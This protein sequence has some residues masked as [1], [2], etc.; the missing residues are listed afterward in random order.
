MTLT[1]DPGKPTYAAIEKTQ[2]EIFAFTSSIVSLRGGRQ[3]GKLGL[4]MTP[5]AYDIFDPATP[6]ILPV[7]TGNPPTFDGMTQCVIHANQGQYIA[8]VSDFKNTNQLEQQL[9]NLLLSA[10]NRK[11][12]AVIMDTITGQIKKQLPLILSLLYTNYEQITPTALNQKRDACTNLI[13]NPR[14][15]IDQI[16]VKIMS[17]SLMAQAAKSPATNEQ[18]INIGIIILQH[19]GFFT[20]DIRKCIKL[21]AQEH[22]RKTFQE[23]FSKS[24]LELELARP[25]A[26]SMG[27]HNQY[28]NSADKIVNKLYENISAD[29][30]APA[31]YY[32]K[33]E[34]AA[35]T[36][37]NQHMQQI[38]QATQQNTH[39]QNVLQKP[40]F[41]SS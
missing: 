21:P 29:T 8:R 32:E 7:H 14:E 40:Y 33:S 37:M 39:T 20:H 11:W 30:T 35:A 4:V 2:R 18:L 12:L 31:A 9:T 17:Y 22:N 15:P 34:V 6:Y 16:W 19:A 24:Q 3:H 10:Y 13:Y 38:A 36:H 25:T 1:A 41:S 27:F 23:H 26:N 28:A 5:S